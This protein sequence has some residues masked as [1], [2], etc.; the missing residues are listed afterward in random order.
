MVATYTKS[1]DS[2]HAF[3]VPTPISQLAIKLQPNLEMPHQRETE[4]LMFRNCPSSQDYNKVDLF[5]AL[6]LMLK[7]TMFKLAMNT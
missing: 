2:T 5:S 1:T 6:I 4:I 3:R 7:K